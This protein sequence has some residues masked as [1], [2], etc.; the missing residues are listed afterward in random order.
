MKRPDNPDHL[1][2]EPRL[3]QW[4]D[5]PYNEE[6]GKSSQVGYWIRQGLEHISKG[7]RRFFTTEAVLDFLF[8]S[9]TPERTE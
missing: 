6:T 7:E 9:E 5:L 8:N 1:L 2:S 4:L 3:C